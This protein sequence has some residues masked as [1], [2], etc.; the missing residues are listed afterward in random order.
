MLYSDSQSSL[1]V[2]TRINNYYCLEHSN[3]QLGL[4]VDIN[5]YLLYSEFLV[6]YCIYFSKM[7]HKILPY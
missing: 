5:S 7:I 2:N 6:S 1:R 4:L 3:P